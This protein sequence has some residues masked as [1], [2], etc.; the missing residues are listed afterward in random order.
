MA[1]NSKTRLEALFPQLSSSSYQIKS[2][3]TPQYNCIAWAAEEDD[4]WWEPVPV[5]GY[6]WPRRIP[7]EVTLASLT[8][9]FQ[10]LGYRPG[11]DETLEAGCEKIAIYA[12]FSGAPT[13][14]A[15]QLAN[16]KWTSKI[17]TLEDIEHDLEGLT[18]SD[19]GT[20][21]QIMKRSA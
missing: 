13:H 15:R 11:A 19:Y 17:G 12:D 20:V 18:L 2:P 8:M 16:G 21:A 6:Y 9:L 1:I 5:P 10:R 14:V 7:R 3:A 4:R